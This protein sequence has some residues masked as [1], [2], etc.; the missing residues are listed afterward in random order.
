MS[1][2]RSNNPNSH[3]N[4]DTSSTVAHIVNSHSSADDWLLLAHLT[5]AYRS[6]LDGLMDG[7]GLHRG[8]VTVLCR[9]FERDGMTQSEIADRLSVQGAT[10]TNMLQRM[11][12]AGLVSRRRD[13]QDNRLVR[14]YLTDKG[15]SKE[16]S[17]VE[18]A[19]RVEQS[20]FEGLSDEE[21][22]VLRSMMKVMLRNM[23][24]DS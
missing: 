9:L 21:R 15:R 23:E 8:Q 13:P 24:N 10:I 22:A 2:E 14:V 18:Q 5:Q 12:E 6:M 7:V 1:S 17:I 20:V 4:T 19:F 16:R 11:E 3:T